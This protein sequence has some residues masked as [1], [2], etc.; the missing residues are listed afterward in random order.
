MKNTGNKETDGIGKKKK[1]EIE[2][3]KYGDGRRRGTRLAWIS[4]PRGHRDVSV[5]RGEGDGDG[6]SDGGDFTRVSQVR[7]QQ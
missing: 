5:R 2:M 7:A 4:P 1:R 6:D 3:I